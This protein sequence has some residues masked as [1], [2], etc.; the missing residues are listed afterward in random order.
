VYEGE[1][2]IVAQMPKGVLQGDRALTAMVSVQACNEEVCLP[3][4]KLP[5]KVR[6][7][8]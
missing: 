8:R 1:V 3:P 7:S 6:V 2:A 4:A 5:L